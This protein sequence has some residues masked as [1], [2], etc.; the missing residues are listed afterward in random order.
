MAHE[1]VAGRSPIDF[2]LDIRSRHVQFAGPPWPFIKDRATASRTETANGTRICLIALQ[3]V[4][5]ASHL[6]LFFLKANPGHEGRSM[7]TSAVGAMA[8]RTELAGQAH[9]ELQ[10]LAQAGARHRSSSLRIAQHSLSMR[11]LV[12]NT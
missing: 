7:G 3:A 5:T 12:Q 4:Q 2:S 1:V 10:R 8:M 9:L 11:P 6:D